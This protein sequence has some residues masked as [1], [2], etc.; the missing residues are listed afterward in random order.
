M[1]NDN[2]VFVGIGDSFNLLEDE[3]KVSLCRVDVQYLLS[4]QIVTI[5]PQTE[6]YTITRGAFNISKLFTRVSISKDKCNISIFSSLFSKIKIVV[7][8]R[9]GN[10]DTLTNSS[11]ET[12]KGLE[13]NRV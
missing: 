7:I 12:S 1:D 2:S 10:R 13:T 9:T 6:V 8:Q 11:L 5:V 4:Y 3:E